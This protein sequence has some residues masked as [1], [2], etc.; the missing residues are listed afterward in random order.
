VKTVAFREWPYSKVTAVKE[1]KWK[2][3]PNIGL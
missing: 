1:L 3:V 2:S